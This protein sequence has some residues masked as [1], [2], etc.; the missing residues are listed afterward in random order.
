MA[1]LSLSTFDCI[2]VL[3]PS[4]RLFDRVGLIPRVY[5]RTGLDSGGEGDWISV[6]E[7]PRVTWWGLFLNPEGNLHHAFC[8]AVDRLVDDPQN[9][10]NQ[11]VVR[12]IVHYHLKQRLMWPPGRAFQ[13][14]VVV[15][16]HSAGPW[17]E[18][19]VLISGKDQI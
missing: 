18:Q 19:D 8:N 1:N 6:L 11:K 10:A 17:L 14:K 4:W 12:K 5:V 13:F 9:S 15:R 16:K 7:A 2:R 3:I